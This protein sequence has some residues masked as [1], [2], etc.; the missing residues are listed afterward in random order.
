MSAAS[1]VRDLAGIAVAI[2]AAL[3]GI[4][5]RLSIFTVPPNAPLVDPTHRFP[6]FI[7]LSQGGRRNKTQPIY[8]N[9]QDKT[10]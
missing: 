10:R 3:Q 6:D 5:S 8:Q 9:A 7:V 4:K 2:R 1:S